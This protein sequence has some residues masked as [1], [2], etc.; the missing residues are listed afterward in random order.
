MSRPADGAVAFPVDRSVV[1]GGL[2]IHYLEWERPNGRPLLLLHGIARHAHSFDHLARQLSEDYRII[3]PDLRGHGDSQWD[4]NGA[5]LI[6][7]YVRDI[8]RLVERLELRDVVV[9]GNSTGGRVAQVMAGTHGGSIAATIVE[10]VGPERPPEVSARR[11]RRM[12]T[13]ANGWSSIEELT[14]RAM[15]DNPR[16]AEGLVRH[17]VE[18]GATR[19]DG[20][21]VWKRDPAILNGFVPVELWPALRAITSPIIYI[22]GGASDIV[23]P[24]TQA[25]L[26]AVLPH[27]QIATIDGAGHYPSDE[28]PAEFLQIVERFLATALAR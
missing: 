21:I 27:A 6:D 9:W 15:L 25:R 7:D 22:L 3:A 18:Q 4:P 19:A 13:E 17:L 16:T 1:V 12:A 23:P 26:K 11:V 2:R 8:E 10:D 28:R 20:R 24:A 5:Y 14:A